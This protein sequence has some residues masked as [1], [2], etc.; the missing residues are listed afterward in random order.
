MRSDWWVALILLVSAGAFS[1][2]SNVIGPVAYERVLLASPPRA[3]NH[4]VRYLLEEMTHIATSSVYCDPDPPH[5]DAIFPWGGYCCPN[6]YEGTSRYPVPGEIVVVK[7][8]FPFTC[9]SEFDSVPNARAV[10]LIR[11]PIDSFYSMY[12]MRYLGHPPTERIPQNLLMDYIERWK[13]FQSYWDS[14]SGIM[15]VRY[16]DL[17]L[18]PEIVLD[19][20]VQFI[21]YPFTDE[22]LDRAIKKYPPEGRPLKH[23]SHYLPEDLLLIATELGPFLDKYGYTIDTVQSPAWPD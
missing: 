1:E 6:G 9:E 17:L 13:I 11:H 16:E 4:W 22:D 21:G 5:M 10:R 3:G 14:K 7:S 12:V 19:K 18:Q 8:H 23:I 15:T 2:D 20:L